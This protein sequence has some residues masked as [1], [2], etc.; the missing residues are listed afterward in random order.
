LRQKKAVK[1]Q[2]IPFLRQAKH[3]SGTALAETDAGSMVLLPLNPSLWIYN[4]GLELWFSCMG[5]I[6]VEMEFAPKGSSPDQALGPQ[7]FAG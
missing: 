1:R 3:K 6:G 2:Q 7:R 4:S 5:K